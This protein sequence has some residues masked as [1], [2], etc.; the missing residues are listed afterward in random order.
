MGTKFQGTWA[1]L[2][3]L[4]VLLQAGAPAICSPS[5][6]LAA[7]NDGQSAAAASSPPGSSSAKQESVP[8]YK[9]SHDPLECLHRGNG[10]VTVGGEFGPSWQMYLPSQG[11]RRKR[12]KLGAGSRVC[13]RRKGTG[14]GCGMGNM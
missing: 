12:E 11:S 10:G 8:S 14:M 4:A 1:A 3:F 7:G 6:S 5:T 9:S 13:P 2:F